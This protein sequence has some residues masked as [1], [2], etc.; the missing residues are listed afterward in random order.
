MK[1][2]LL[3]LIS[4]TFLFYSCSTTAIVKIDRKEDEVFTNPKLKAVLRKESPSVVVRAPYVSYTVTQNNINPNGIVYNKLE[5][6]LM[7]NGFTVRDR[8]L[9][10]RVIQQGEV[11]YSR[12]KELGNTDMVLEFVG[13]NENQ[14]RTNR[15]FTPGGAERALR[16]ECEQQ[17]YTYSIEFRVIYIKDNEVAGRYTFYYAPCS[18]EDGCSYK[19]VQNCY[20]ESR[21]T[22]KLIQPYQLMTK[23][24]WERFAETAAERIVAELK[25][26]RN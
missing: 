16:P 9:F 4:S 14:V 2:T 1:K 3:L 10:D 22:K 12:L 17:F 23:T 19:L 7:K 18:D 25:I 24:R 6:E 15:Y 20:F 26:N 5:K 8:A 11:D 13:I 21:K